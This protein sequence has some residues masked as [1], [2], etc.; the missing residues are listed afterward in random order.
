MMNKHEIEIINLL[1]ANS[2]PVTS[3]KIAQVLNVSSRSVRTYIGNINRYLDEKIIIGTSKGYVGVVNKLKKILTE[4]SNN[5]I[6]QNYDD[7]MTLIIKRLLFNHEELNIFDLANDMF[8]SESTIRNDISKI[9]TNYAT[10]NVKFYL[11]V[12]TIKISGSEKDQRK[13]M[14]KFILQE[15]TSNFLD[16]NILQ[17]NFPSIEISNIYSLLTDVFLS[18]EV[19]I[20]EFSK[21]N[22]VLHIAIIIDRVKKKKNIKYNL[23]FKSS[24]EE[25]LLTNLLTEKLANIFE[26]TFDNYE[27]KE[28]LFLIRSNVN[29]FS[30]VDKEIFDLK[31]TIGFFDYVS[32]ILD[33][34]DI[35]YGINLKTNS[36]LSPFLL[37]VSNLYFRLNMNIRNVNPILQNIK[38]ENP[39]IFDISVYISM[40]LAEFLKISLISEEEIAFIALHVGAEI[41]RQKNLEAKFRT[42]IVY[43]NYL[44]L[45]SKIYNK[46]LY[47]FGKEIEIIDI[48]NTYHKLINYKNIDFVITTVPLPSEIDMEYVLIPS[49]NEQLLF[50]SLFEKIDIMKG[51][52]DRAKFIENLDLFILDNHFKNNLSKLANNKYDLITILSKELIEESIISS[53][54]CRDTIKREKSSSTA[55]G[56]LAIPHS[57]EMNADETKI[58]VGIDKNG[59]WWDDESKVNIVLLIAINKDDINIFRNIYETLIYLLDDDNVITY[60]LTSKNGADFKKK[61][62][63]IA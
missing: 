3:E 52:R 2:N 38:H 43:P 46:I 11:D 50:K 44:G 16:I 33:E 20:N 60:L 23:D 57:I 34:I 55:F 49:L 47:R 59:F 29:L 14:S 25:I 26:L 19:Y 54:Y 22:M 27:K 61:L 8:V 35:D 24:E 63:T 30:N 31:T 58:L 39:L 6:P 4:S 12:D 62:R 18:E 53:G 9:N 13:I 45:S 51:K 42:V 37:H 7:R 5:S 21:M 56:K 17:E 15:S 48:L 36:F 40:K 41:D 28:I 32:D 1:L 10:N